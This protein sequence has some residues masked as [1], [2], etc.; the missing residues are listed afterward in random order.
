MLPYIYDR[1]ISWVIDKLNNQ[2][3]EGPAENINLY[4]NGAE[5]PEMILV[6]IG[7]TRY[8]EFGETNF[9][10]KGDRSVVILYPESKYSF[11][12]I[13]QI[14]S[15]RSYNKDDISVLDQMVEE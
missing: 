13:K 15:Q 5:R 10:K 14:V 4:L 9:L 7:A 1:L 3:D 8:T 2:K 12:D 11:S 6:S